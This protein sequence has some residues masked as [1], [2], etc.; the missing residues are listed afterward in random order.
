MPDNNI[1]TVV[2]ESQMTINM[3][4]VLAGW[5]WKVFPCSAEKNP[6]TQH[7][8]YDATTDPIKIKAWR[9]WPLIGIYC[10]GSDIFAVDIDVKGGV[11]GYKSFYGLVETYGGGQSVEVGPI[12]NTPSGGQHLIFRLPEDCHIPNNAKK[13][14]PG[15]DLRSA[16]YI[17]TGK[18][19]TWQPDH[20]PDSALTDAPGWLLD[21]IRAMTQP[22]TTI[23]VPAVT[24]TAPVNETDSAGS[25]LNKYVGEARVG[26][27]NQTGFLLSMQLRDSGVGWGEAENTMRQYANSVPQ[28]GTD[29]YTEKEALD[30][31]AVAYKSPPRKAATLPT[32][33]VETYYQTQQ[34]MYPSAEQEDDKG[35][36]WKETYPQWLLDVRAEHPEDIVP[37][38][39]G[40]YTIRTMKEA[41]SP[42]PEVKMVVGGLFA[43]GDMGIFCGDGG[44]GKT[45]VLLHLAECIASGT[46]WL[47]KPVKKGN[48]L[49]IDEESGNVRLENR[50]GEIARGLGLDDNTPIAHISYAGLNFSEKNTDEHELVKLIKWFDASVVIIDALADVMSGDENSKQDTQ[51]VFQHLRW[52][53]NETGAAIVIIHHHNKSGKYRGSTAIR[54]SLDFMVDVDKEGNTIS[55]ETNKNRDG[56]T[57]KWAAIASWQGRGD[58]AIFKLVPTEATVQAQYGK[59]QQYVIRFLEDNSPATIEE[60]QNSADVCSPGSA[61][62]AVYALVGA[63]KIY[64]TNKG[65]QGSKAEYAIKNVY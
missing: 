40:R 35:P 5:G 14:A 23:S 11:D 16:G 28:S 65:G 27:R 10:E 17:C 42:H 54:A 49:F 62:L 21:R 51:P 34:P 38:G 39:E 9:E 55:F 20:G 7:G 60:I 13:L 43:P 31:L 63:G 46:E 30:S 44:C 50:L 26:D 53:A 36:G 47:D 6:I 59:A 19:Y 25:W 64:R 18:G 57:T 61:R 48:V 1:T 41:L 8:F 29:T 2:S 15:L 45:Y 3:A 37:P 4:L 52:A 58:E 24:R 33:R 32:A 56:E 22:P 12:Q